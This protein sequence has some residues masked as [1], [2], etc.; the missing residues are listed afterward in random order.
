MVFLKMSQK[1]REKRRKKVQWSHRN[2]SEIPR[3]IS[4]VYAFWCRE[5]DKCVYVGKAA[6]QSVRNRLIQHWRG[7]H[8]RILKLWIQAF[9]E[10]LDVCYMSVELSKVDDFER[11]LIKLWKPEANVQ[12]R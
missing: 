9:G 2:I 3:S 7:S 4:G 12:H 5:N 10:Y 11:R 1:K 8:N 6:E